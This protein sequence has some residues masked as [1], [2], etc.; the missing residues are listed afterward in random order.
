MDSLPYL[1]CNV[2][3]GWLVKPVRWYCATFMLEWRG[4]RILCPTLYWSA[5]T[6]V[7]TIAKRSILK[8]NHL[9][10]YN[11]K[12]I[13]SKVSYF[14]VLLSVEGKS[15]CTKRDRGEVDSCMH[16]YKKSVYWM[17]QRG[18]RFMHAQ[19]WRKWVWELASFCSFVY[20]N[21]YLFQTEI[22]PW[23]TWEA[24]Q[25]ATELTNPHSLQWL[26]ED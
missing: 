7:T 5:T 24:F 21:T 23:E 10:D 19:L 2:H 17:R 20:T 25:A 12:K 3:V 22:F 15:Q 13:D 18:G 14:T 1:S 4:R 9:S 26:N 16:N 6:W 8:C 11:S